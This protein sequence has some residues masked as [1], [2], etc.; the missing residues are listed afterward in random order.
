MLLG[1][2]GL[3][4]ELLGFGGGVAVAVEGGMG[5]VME[6]VEVREDVG[7]VEV[8]MGFWGWTSSSKFAQ[9]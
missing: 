1:P 4:G 5:P 9:L 7:I 2:I 8:S 3:V 6:A